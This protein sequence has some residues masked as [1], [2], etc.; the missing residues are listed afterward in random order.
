MYSECPPKI[1]KHCEITRRKR[2]IQQWHSGTQVSCTDLSFPKS[3]AYYHL[4][5]CSNPNIVAKGWACT[6]LSMRFRNHNCA[7]I[8][9]SEAAETIRLCFYST[10]HQK[11]ELAFSQTKWKP[12]VAMPYLSRVTKLL[13]VHTFLLCF[14]LSASGIRCIVECLQRKLRQMDQ[15]HCCH[16]ASLF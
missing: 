10:H 7:N 4:V 13:S 2:N 12:L 3:T 11:N 14:H 5:N 16:F 9:R 15:M 6:D 8:S 1:H